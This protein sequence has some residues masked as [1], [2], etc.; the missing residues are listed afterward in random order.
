M[1]AFLQPGIGQ[2]LII[3]AI[4]LLFFGHQLPRLCR[5]LV[6]NAN[7]LLILVGNRKWV[8][9][10]LSDFFFWSLTFVLLLAI[11]VLVV[12]RIR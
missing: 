12:G 5:Q 10:C 11:L 2:L 1:I 6:S 9:K 7:E 3:L 8:D 4:A